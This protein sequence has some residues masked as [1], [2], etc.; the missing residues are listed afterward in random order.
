MPPF[1]ASTK[2]VAEIYKVEDLVRKDVLDSIDAEE[3]IA[4]FKKPKLLAKH[5]DW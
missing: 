1:D 5:K 2:N 3:H 4:L